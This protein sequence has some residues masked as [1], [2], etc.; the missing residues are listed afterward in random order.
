MFTLSMPTQY[1]ENAY[2]WSLGK[3][4]DAGLPEQVPALAPSSRGAMGENAS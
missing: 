2:F 3:S 4:I 1:T